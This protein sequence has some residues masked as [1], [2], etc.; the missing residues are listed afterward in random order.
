MAIFSILCQKWQFFHRLTKGAL[1][2]CF[3]QYRVPLWFFFT[4]QCRIHIV[5]STKVTTVWFITSSMY[6]FINDN[7]GYCYFSNTK[8]SWYCNCFCTVGSMQSFTDHELHNTSK[9]TLC[10]KIGWYKPHCSNFGGK[11]MCQ[12]CP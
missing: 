6:Q 10:T 11:P 7:C 9:S 5:L 1:C 3:I 12:Q 8:R 4:L 2:L